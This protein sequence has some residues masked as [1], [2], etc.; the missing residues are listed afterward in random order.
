MRFAR[1]QIQKK[2]QTELKTMI[3]IIIVST[4]IIWLFY[5]KIFPL[6]GQQND[7]AKCQRSIWLSA[8]SKKATG[9]NPLASP[10]CAPG[11]VLIKYDDVVEDGKINQDKA[12]KIIADAMARCWWMAGEGKYDPFSNWNYKEK[13]LCLICDTIKFDEPLLDFMNKKLKQAEGSKPVPEKGYMI[14]SPLLYLTSHR[15]SDREDA[16]TYYKYLWKVDLEKDL[17]FKDA[18]MVKNYPVLP[19][20]LIILQMIKL[21][22]KSTT[23]QYIGFGTSA[24]AIIGG[25]ILITLG[26]LGTPLSFGSSNVLTAIGVNLLVGA[27]SVIVG[28]AAIMPATIQ[29]TFSDCKD[30]NAVGGVYLISP[31]ESLT[32]PREV[33]INGK[34]KKFPLC[35]VIVN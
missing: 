2:A 6:L 29:Y 14:D 35:S 10:D 30:C 27:T 18:K 5:G 21:K 17:E 31:T 15:I 7:K 33:K 26:L 25:G 16:P 3:L 11:E 23:L 13:P 20:S 22:Q 9:G 1:R 19:E 24:M 12:H 32:S 28:A 34:S 4:V 8:M